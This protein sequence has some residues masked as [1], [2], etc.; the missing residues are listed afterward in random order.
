MHGASLDDLRQTG[1]PTPAFAQLYLAIRQR[2]DTRRI[3]ATIFQPAQSI[4][5]NG[6]SF[7]FAYVSDNPAHNE[8]LT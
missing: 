1:D 8:K 4:D 2:R 3:V 7:R 6:R 5:K